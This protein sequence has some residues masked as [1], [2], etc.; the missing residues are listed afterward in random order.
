MTLTV[1]AGDGKRPQD[2]TEEMAERIKA[3][4]YDYSDRTT[5]AAA[6]GVLQIVAAEILEE[7]Q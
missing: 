2:V 1:I 4:I 3:V 7:A 6:L 5:L